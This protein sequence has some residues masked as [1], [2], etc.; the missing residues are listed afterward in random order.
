MVIDAAAGPFA[1]VQIAGMIARR[2]VCFTHEGERLSAGDRFGLIR[3]GSRV[4]VYMPE[5]AR[6]LVG[7]H[8]RAV[9]GE[10]VIAEIGRDEGLRQFRL[11]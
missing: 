11:S 1:V 10:T 4:D 5:G 3:F 8:S 7:L 2:I 6:I 9:A